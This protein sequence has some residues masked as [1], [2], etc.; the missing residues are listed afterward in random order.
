MNKELL[1]L[2]NITFAY[3]S[4]PVVDDVSLTVYEGDFIGLVGQNGSGKTTLLKLMIGLLKPNSGEI[5]HLARRFV[6]YVPQKS[7]QEGKNFPITCEEL[8]MQGRVAK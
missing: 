4:E 3:N 6:G 5:S 1:T 7:S 2:K 8:V